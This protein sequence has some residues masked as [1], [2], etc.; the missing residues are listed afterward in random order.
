[1]FIINNLHIYSSCIDLL[2]SVFINFFSTLSG[3]GNGDRDL[4]YEPGPSLS[5]PF[6]DNKKDP[7]LNL[8]HWGVW[9]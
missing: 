1:M 4:F 3:G 9:L 2:Y 6:V 7:S 8:A 5:L